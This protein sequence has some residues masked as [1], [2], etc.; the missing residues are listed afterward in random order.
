MMMLTAGLLLAMRKV[1]H[2][3]NDRVDEEELSCASFSTNCCYGNGTAIIIIKYTIYIT[4]QYSGTSKLTYWL[5]S[6]SSFCLPHSS[7]PLNLTQHDCS[8]FGCKILMPHVFTTPFTSRESS[9]VLCNGRS[10]FHSI[11]TAFLAEE[12]TFQTVCQHKLGRKWER[13]R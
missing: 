1:C 10:Y 4:R 5:F 13:E 6:S 9:R 12:Q 7:A 2:V 11:F 8:T 3:I